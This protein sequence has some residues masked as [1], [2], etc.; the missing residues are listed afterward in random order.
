MPPTAQATQA[1]RPGPRTAGRQ[2]ARIDAARCLPARGGRVERLAL[3]PG[4]PSVL[5]VADLEPFI[6]SRIPQ[7]GRLDTVH[8][9][10][11]PYQV[12]TEPGRPRR[13][14][15]ICPVCRR[16]ARY[17]YDRTTHDGPDGTSSQAR[18]PG[19]RWTCRACSGIR[20][21]AP[22]PSLTAALRDLARALE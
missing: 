7:A 4:R 16:Q 3:I 5:V 2:P 19:W 8:I 22:R 20:W 21:P 1:D 12:Q 6:V 14:A 13:W 17:L 11:A 18:A 9:D 10:G 15:F